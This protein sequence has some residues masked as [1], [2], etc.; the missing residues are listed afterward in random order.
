MKT[1]VIRPITYNKLSKNDSIIGID[2][3]WYRDV[4]FYGEAYGV[5]EFTHRCTL[6]YYDIDKWDFCY[7]II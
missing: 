7:R 1:V 6:V 5:Q 3:I 2:E 4:T